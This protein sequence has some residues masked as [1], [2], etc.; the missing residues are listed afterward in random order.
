MTG[1]EILEM[2]STAVVGASAAIVA[3]LAFVGLTE[4][5]RRARFEAARKMLGLAKKFSSEIQQSRSPWGYQGEADDRPRS[6]HEAEDNAAALDERYV[7]MKR[8]QPS[9]ETLRELMQSTWEA[10]AVLKNDLSREIQ[11]FVHI[12][13]K[14]ALAVEQ[15]Y[16][17]SKG[18]ESTK[19]EFVEM[20]TI[21][22][23]PPKPDDAISTMLQ[24][25]TSQLQKTLK[26]HI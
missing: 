3:I 5:R 7:R 19:D 15:Q 18:A 26:K 17:R 21:I 1:R 8:L 20:M 2:A 16:F 13:N 12:H 23:G 6:T 10:E 24:E 9:A 14:I 4:W 11:A 22:Y 25:A